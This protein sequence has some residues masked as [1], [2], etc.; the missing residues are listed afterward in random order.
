MNS[1]C[2]CSADKRSKQQRKDDAKKLAAQ[3]KEDERLK[4]KERKWREEQRRQALQKADADA[5]EVRLKLFSAQLGPTPS[6]AGTHCYLCPDL[7]K[8]PGIYSISSNLQYLSLNMPPAAGLPYTA[9]F[10]QPLT[11]VEV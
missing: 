11:M 8:A 3:R 4:A 2:N 9:A 5:E 1:V 10:G 6:T 7:P